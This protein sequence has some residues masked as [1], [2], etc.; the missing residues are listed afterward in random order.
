ML[1]PVIIEEEK[2]V[3]FSIIV[4]DVVGAV[5]SAPNEADIPARV[6]GVVEACME[7]SDQDLPTP[8]AAAEVARSEEAKDGFV[9]LVDVDFSFLNK[10]TERVN[11]TVPSYLLHRIDK[12]AKQAGKNRSQYLVDCALRCAPQR[13]SST[14]A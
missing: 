6:Q 9:M 10:K 4:P 13:T 2:G 11:I 3:G 7:F 14:G 8:S 12:D 1:L 5:T